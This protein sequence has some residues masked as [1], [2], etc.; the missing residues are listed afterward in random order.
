MA[1]KEVYAEAREQYAELGIDTEKAMDTLH[2]IPVSMHCWQGDDVGGFEHPGATL[3][4]GGIQVTGNYPGKARSI[5][6]LRADIEKALS[7]APGSY[8][9]NLHAS[10]ADFSETKAVDRDQLEKKHFQSW[11]DWGKSNHIPLDFNATF[12]AHPKAAGMTLSSKDKGIRDFWIEH[13]KRC[14]EIGGWFGKEQ[15]S[16][17]IHNLWVADGMKDIPADRKG[18]RE[19]LASSY[20]EIMSL[21]IPKEYLKDSFESKVFGIGSESFV[22]GS[23]EF[24]MGYCVKN[25]HMI[26]LD[27][28]HFH[29]TENVADKISSMLM[30][31]PELL[32][33]ISRGVRWDSDHVCILNDDL[34]MIA[35][36]LVRSGKMEK[37]HIATDFFDGSI[38][39]VGAWALG[40][41]ATEKA[42]L[43]ALLQNNE[44]L[45]AAEESGN[46]F[47]R[48]AL[49]EAYKTLPFGAV[50]DRYCEMS[51]VPSDLEV[52][53]EVMD[54][55]KNVQSK[56]K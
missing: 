33:H 44:K 32:F 15:G 11:L 30:F 39:R 4:G 18:Y 40:L 31:V 35:E 23:H 37:I 21:D 25:H 47:E 16:A 6:E 52:V 45:V 27:M 19:I 12:F 28:G 34:K 22:V 7:L 48:L 42:M 24:Y 43:Y 49:G 8:R 2:K 50:W 51:N 5:P 56:R 10:Y 1:K 26:T 46:Y 53:K 14:R 55:E 29:P 54:Y 38:N 20:D 3:D 13:A 41:R 9:L 17:C 36:E